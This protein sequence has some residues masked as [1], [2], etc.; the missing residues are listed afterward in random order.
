MRGKRAVINDN[1]GHDFPAQ[2]K[3]RKSRSYVYS[4]NKQD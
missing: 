3:G 4:V 2:E 1:M